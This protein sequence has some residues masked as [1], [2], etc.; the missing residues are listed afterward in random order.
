MISEFTKQVRAD[1]PIFAKREKPLIYFDSAATS[2]KPQIVID[3]INDYYSKA[4]GTVHRAVYDLAADATKQ[5]NQVRE[6]VA[7]FIGAKDQREIIFTR[8]T[9]DSIN[10]LANALAD[11]FNPG[12]E[13]ILSEMEHHSNIVPWQLLAKRKKLILR[14]IPVNDKAELDLDAYQDL[15]TP[16]T[17]LVAIAHIANSTGSINPIQTIIGLAHKSGAK[18]LID[19]AQSTAHLPIDVKADD[20]DYLA[21]SAHKAFGPTGVGILYGKYELLE[22]LPPVQG[23]GDMIETVALDK[24]TFQPPPLRFEA[25]T[26][27]IAGILGFGAALS[28]IEQLG[29]QNIH[30]WEQKLLSHATSTLEKIPDLRIIGNA[31]NKAGIISF[32]IDGVHHLDLGTLLNLE[33]IAIRTGHHCAQPLLAR[34]GLTGTCRISFA[35]FNTLQEIDQFVAALQKALTLLV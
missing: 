12:D 15:L 9:T 13:I 18:V 24:S 30:T 26:P 23:G 22:K 31:E 27:N 32:V 14:Y 19:A 10:I 4:C 6:H 25:G 5:Y 17:K 20:I 3:A 11:Q 8:G 2:Q 21:L 33:G 7:R 16:K 1:F 29:L 34:F 35:P 28:Y